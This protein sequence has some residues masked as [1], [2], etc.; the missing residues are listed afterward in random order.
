MD[1]AFL[2]QEDRQQRKVYSIR[3]YKVLWRKLQAGSGV[4][5]VLGNTRGLQVVR[6]GL[7]PKA[8]F[9]ERLRGKEVVWTFGDK[10]APGRRSST[11]KGPELAGSLVPPRNSEKVSMAGNMEGGRE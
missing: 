2:W 5:G 9:E 7:L 10:P 3:R 8:R 6:A 1:L 11:C 4:C